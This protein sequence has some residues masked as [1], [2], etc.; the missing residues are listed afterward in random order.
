MSRPRQPAD[1]AAPLLAAVLL[2]Y[3]GC[4]LMFRRLSALLG[5]A[6]GTAAP[7]EDDS[8]VRKLQRTGQIILDNKEL[9]REVFAVESTRVG[10]ADEGQ[11]VSC[12]ISE[13][14][15]ARYEKER[16]RSQRPAAA[17]D[18]NDAESNKSVPA[19]T[20]P[21]PPK[22]LLED[23]GAIRKSVLVVD[24]VTKTDDA[25][26]SGGAVVVVADAKSKPGEPA[27]RVSHGKKRQAPAP[28]KP[29]PA[30]P[31]KSNGAAAVAL[32]KPPEQLPKLEVEPARTTEAERQKSHAAPSEIIS[33]V[34]KVKGA[35]ESILIEKAEPAVA[36]EPPRE[37]AVGAKQVEDQTEKLLKISSEI[38]L[39]IAEFRGKAEGSCQQWANKGIAEADRR[40]QGQGCIPPGAAAAPLDKCV[41]SVQVGEKATAQDKPVVR[42]ESASTKEG[43][44]ASPAA[45]VEAAKQV[46]NK[47]VTVLTNNQLN[48]EIVGVKAE[49]V[50]CEV[51]TA[52]KPATVP[53]AEKKTE[54]VPVEVSSISKS[55]STGDAES[56]ECPLLHAALTLTPSETQTA[57]DSNDSAPVEVRAVQSEYAI[58]TEPLK[59]P[60]DETK[61]SPEVTKSAVKVAKPAIQK[62]NLP[63]DKAKELQEKERLLAKTISLSPKKERALVENAKLLL[64]AEKS[65]VKNSFEAN[66]SVPEPLIQQHAA[67]LVQKQDISQ[68]E[69]QRSA[70]V[71]NCSHHEAQKSTTEEKLVDQENPTP[72]TGECQATTE[73]SSKETV[74]SA[75][76]AKPSQE[77]VE[78][79]TDSKIEQSSITVAAEKSNSEGKQ[80]IAETE[81]NAGEAVNCGKAA[82]EPNTGPLNEAPTQNLESQ[83][84]E[85]DNPT[86]E[87]PKPIESA[88]VQVQEAKEEVEEV[89]LQNA[90]SDINNAIVVQ[91]APTESDIKVDSGCAVAAV[92][93]EEKAAESIISASTE[94]KSGAASERI[95]TVAEEP[96]TEAQV[97]VVQAPRLEAPAA[98]AVKSEDLIP[99]N[100]TVDTVTDF[101]NISEVLSTEEELE[102]PKHIEETASTVE[103]KEDQIAEIV[104][105]DAKVEGNPEEAVIEVTE[106]RQSEIDCVQPKGE[107]EETKSEALPKE[108]KGPHSTD[109]PNIDEPLGAPK[110]G[111]KPI[112]SQISKPIE[113]LKVEDSDRVDAAHCNGEPKGDQVPSAADEG[114]E[115]DHLMKKIE[116]FLVTENNE[117][118]D[119]S[120]SEAAVKLDTRNCIKVKRVSSMKRSEKISK[121]ALKKEADGQQETDTCESQGDGGKNADASYGIQSGKVNSNADKKIKT[122]DA[123]KLA[124]SAGKQPTQPAPKIGFGVLRPARPKSGAFFTSDPQQRPKSDELSE[125]FNKIVLRKAEEKRKSEQ[126]ALKS[127][128]E[129]KVSRTGSRKTKEKK[130][131]ANGVKEKSPSKTRETSPLKNGQESKRGDEKSKLKSR[132]SSPLKE[133]KAK[134]VE[135][136]K[137]EPAADS[138]PNSEIAE[139]KSNASQVQAE[140][141]SKESGGAVATGDQLPPTVANSAVADAVRPDLC[142]AK[143][144]VDTS[145]ACEA[146]KTNSSSINIKA[147]TETAAASGTKRDVSSSEATCV[148]RKDAP[149]TLANKEVGKSAEKPSEVTRLVRRSSKSPVKNVS[150]GSSVEP[151]TAANEANQ[152]ESIDRST[153][154]GKLVLGQKLD[155]DAQSSSSSQKEAENAKK[156]ESVCDRVAERLESIQA[157]KERPEE[158]GNPVNIEPETT[159]SAVDGQ[160]ATKTELVDAAAAKMTVDGADGGG[161][162]LVVANTGRKVG[163]TRYLTEMQV[164]FRSG[165]LGQLEAQ[166]DEKLQ[167]HVTRLQARCKGYLARRRFE[168]RKV[169]EVA[170]R[171]VQ[172]NVRRFLKVRDWPWWRLL[173]RVAPLL[174]VHRA[175]EE[176]RKQTEELEGLKMRLDKSEAEKLRLK[177][178]NERLEA[179][180]NELTVALAEEQSA[181][182]LAAERLK[183][184]S[185]ERSRLQHELQ[186]AQEKQSSL[187][188]ASQRLEMEI[189]MCRATDDSSHTSGDDDDAGYE[190]LK[191]RLDRAVKEAAALRRQLQQ[192]QEANED[193]LMALRKATE[194]RV[195]DAL[196][197]VE[198]QR[199]VVAQM[200]RKAQRVTGE[201]ND[202]RLMLEEQSARNAILEKRQKKFDSEM[203]QLQES[204]RLEKSGKE[205]AL[206]ERD[207]MAAE[208]T[209]AEQNLAACRLELEMRD[210]KVASLGRELEEL[211]FG[212]VA[213]EE[214]ATLRK[215]KHT[216]ERRVKEQ[217]EE[218]D[219]LAGQVGLLEAA[220]VRLEMSL[221]QQR[222][223]SKREYS[224]RDDEL[225]E[226]RGNAQK[227]VR[228]LESQLETEHEERTRLLR[229]KHDLERRLAEAAEVARGRA[230]EDEQT[231]QRLRRELRHA[232][233]L[234][235]DAHGLLERQRDETGGRG[236]LRALRHQLED[237]EAARA[238]AM[239]ARQTAEA[240]A[241]ELQAVLE[242]ERRGRAVAED[243]AAAAVRART[244]V[245]GQL[246]EN[247][248]ELAE[249]MKKYKAAVAQISVEQAATTELAVTA[250]TLEAERNSLREQV[251][252]MSARLEAAE[253]DTT[254]G[255]T[256]RR[257]ETKIR[258]L[259]S[260][261]ELEATTRARAETQSGRFREQADKMAV[262]AE[263]ARLREAT[264]N[265]AARRSARLLREARER[266]ASVAAK[267]AE[268]IRK[269][270][271][272]ELRVETVEAEAAQARA[273][274]RLAL[275]RIE[276]LQAA[277]AGDS[278]DLGSESSGSIESLLDS[279]GE[280]HEFLDFACRSPE[281][282]SDPG[283]GVGHLTDSKDESHA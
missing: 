274:L 13:I 174:N 98:E 9:I 161:I 42:V 229:E 89:T 67:N 63:V 241:R 24:Q 198:E 221:E 19:A 99:N 256:A 248:E 117:D 232:K 211:A 258:E 277:M 51:I 168:K 71:E 92:K 244:E 148:A 22:R 260:R 150:K 84:A 35:G 215:A 12:K 59:T 110:E 228:A 75:D 204:L 53:T 68:P 250:A 158:S 116:S 271:E 249:V 237:A 170:V 123:T 61:L 101:E 124:A 279:V 78:N 275:L 212:G 143:K 83:P 57:V 109:A 76:I 86:E 2:F 115:E 119:V 122:D 44:A 224:Q 32:H 113:A 94:I 29:P 179:R 5:P 259:E 66:K 95:E 74:A 190:H 73:K 245:A 264:A 27:A 213:E 15:E 216:L 199:Q 278:E 267:E 210:E 85:G 36:V 239:K 47:D 17:D 234:L 222:K 55:P 106:N 145:T 130:P 231:I 136:P 125:V 6:R 105:Q 45:V 253:G 34:D 65:L 263:A 93:L 10:G 64:E 185:V 165:V 60:T 180:M 121:L 159:P 21:L 50:S 194:K 100:T 97:E 205:K 186:N 269:R 151:K 62:V 79:L 132:E 272:I 195:A 56:V 96:S 220:K 137:T 181:S 40:G 20:P 200:K 41:S 171:C 163:D 187:R 146:Q 155:K 80:E 270:K 243:R 184:E 90:A 252:E 54:V 46:D 235:R 128:S 141:T 176:L 149:L 164:F 157:V 233:A 91:L 16:R 254:T 183:T 138:R 135:I 43:Q 33:E 142:A 3:L 7:E 28:P 134:T 129:S 139:E 283:D 103:E 111:E 265:D 225:E 236:Q 152:T 37:V 162:G 282:Q 69:L 30:E 126:G 48:K 196:E 255:L 175:E 104:V 23:G 238:V 169:Q 38:K 120:M 273:D 39:A 240:E 102:R 281:G 188:E 107:P 208:K 131:E 197:E 214:V 140:K 178:H 153:V 81:I 72:D 227:K 108:E 266:E 280:S 191:Q 262:E 276:D 4:L 87:K 202:T 217:E 127:K 192:Q 58:T 219:E 11:R 147:G 226:I 189:L 112:E 182:H 160:P 218:L 177:Q 261:L 114:D 209:A 207:L 144:E 173:V 172:R 14:V 18:C 257:L 133:S 156:P 8:D 167:D 203:H 88:Q 82:S 118:D 49:I 251:A 201:H 246:E 77:A 26:T 52:E 193:Q 230:P 223:E 25:D 70:T 154:R 31:I 206:R 268:A 247:E 242:E 1:E 166:R